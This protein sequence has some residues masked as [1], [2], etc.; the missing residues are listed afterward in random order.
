MVPIQHAK[1]L[2]TLP[3]PLHISRGLNK[4]YGYTS[5]HANLVKVNYL[6]WE[7]YRDF[8]RYDLAINLNSLDSSDRKTGDRVSFMHDSTSIFDIPKII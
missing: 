7:Y 5:R 6:V 8:V 3:V 1:E 4:G 2:K